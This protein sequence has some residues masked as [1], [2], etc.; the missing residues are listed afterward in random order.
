MDLFY[1]SSKHLACVAF[2][3]SIAGII[4]MCLVFYCCAKR[5]SE[6]REPANHQLEM[7]I[8]DYET[9]APKRYKYSEVKKMQNSFQEELGRGGYGSVYK[10]RSPDGKLVAVKLLAGALGDGE[11]FVNEVLCKRK[12]S[13]VSVMGA[14]GT[15]GYMAPE[16]FFKSLGGASHKSDVY[17]YG[18]MVLEMTGAHKNNNV[19]VTSTSETYFPDWIYKKVEAENNL[20]VDGVTSEEEEGLVRK[21]VMVSLWCIQSNPSDRP[22]ISKVV[23]MLEGSLESLQVPPRR[24]WSSPT[25]PIQGASSLGTQSSRCK[26]ISTG[27]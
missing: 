21:M 1:Q 22:S 3:S 9:L 15:A 20:G 12:E 2:S 25:R 24:F 8:K 7:F 23:E 11:D 17:S 27:Q 14:R 16:V 6:T 5:S 4:L 18:M 13:I 19:S 26:S 10:G